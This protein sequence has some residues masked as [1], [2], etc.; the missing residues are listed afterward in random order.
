MKRCA[1]T[2]APIADEPPV[3]PLYTATDAEQ[4]IELTRPF[5]L[6]EQFEAAAGFQARFW[7][8][9]HIFNVPAMA[10]RRG[11]TS[12]VRTEPSPAPTVKTRAK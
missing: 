7:N 4:A 9:G 5:D 8:A 6:E 11:A 10:P 3:K 12:R 1:A 2:A